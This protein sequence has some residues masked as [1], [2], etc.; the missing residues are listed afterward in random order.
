MRQHYLRVLIEI[1]SI[2]LSRLMMDEPAAAGAFDKALSAVTTRTEWMKEG[3]Q[4]GVD[5]HKTTCRQTT[6][7]GRW[8]EGGIVKKI[9]V[10]SAALTIWCQPLAGETW[11]VGRW[12]AAVCVTDWEI[13]TDVQRFPQTRAAGSEASDCSR[14][15]SDTWSQS[16]AREHARAV[17]VHTQ[18]V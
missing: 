15:H 14:G 3:R 6:D 10:Q 5:T 11:Q 18:R 13:R 9:A 17:H 7:D 2:L 1:I 4:E 8:S 16:G 12:A